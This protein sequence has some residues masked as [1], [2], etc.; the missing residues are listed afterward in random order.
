MKRLFVRSASQIRRESNRPFLYRVRW[1]VLKTLRVLKEYLNR[2]RSYRCRG[3]SNQDSEAWPA[4][5]GGG[6]VMLGPAVQEGRT[7]ASPVER[8]LNPDPRVPFST[9]RRPFSNEAFLMR[10]PV[11]NTPAPPVCVRLRR[12]RP[13]DNKY[14][15]TNRPLITKRSATYYT[16]DHTRHDWYDRSIFSNL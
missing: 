7:D 6:L 11:S 2:L 5:E 12:N 1:K 16:T 9:W 14:I 4:V 8:A 3:R 10:R 15:Y 13:V